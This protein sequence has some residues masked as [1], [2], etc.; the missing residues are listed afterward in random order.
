MI[1]LLIIFICTIK[2]QSIQYHKNNLKHEK[3]KQIVTNS[4]TLHY[5]EDYKL[6]AKLINLL[7]IIT[8]LGSHSDNK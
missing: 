5:S 8:S 7:S 3:T 2:A 4:P 6:L 1:T